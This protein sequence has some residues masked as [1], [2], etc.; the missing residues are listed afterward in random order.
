MD[1]I[2]AALIGAIVGAA[3]GFAVGKK[4]APAPAPTTGGAAVDLARMEE[5]LASS[6]AQAELLQGE[7][8]GER[9]RWEKE[10]L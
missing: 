9:G 5:Q 1:P 8:E 10:R 6:K 4:S 2:T 7:R 3:I